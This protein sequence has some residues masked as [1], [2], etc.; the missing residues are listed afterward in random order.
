MTVKA[1]VQKNLER[2]IVAIAFESSNGSDEDRDLI[3]LIRT[4]IMAD[5]DKQSGFVN[6]NRLV[7]HIKT[8]DLQT[9]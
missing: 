8:A 9:L 6:T 1:E 5:I 7:V 4:A 3:D 2:G